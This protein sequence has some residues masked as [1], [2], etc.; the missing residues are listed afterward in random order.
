MAILL[1]NSK[2]IGYVA[3]QTVLS[4]KK[5]KTAQLLV[6][7][8][9]FLFISI[10]CENKYVLNTRLL[11]FLTRT[12][13]HG[14]LIVSAVID[15]CCIFAKCIDSCHLQVK[16]RTPKCSGNFKE[17]STSDCKTI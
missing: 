16:T 14:S 9:Q 13:D 11:R 12:L 4:F 2:I 15:Y 3:D 17:Y 6:R 1:E 5:K 7:T 10:K 8:F